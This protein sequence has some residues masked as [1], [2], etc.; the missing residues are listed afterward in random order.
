MNSTTKN[1][2]FQG[3]N[4]YIGLDVHSKNWSVTIRSQNVNVKRF[5]MN[6]SP[7]ELYQHMQKNYPGGNYHSVYEAGTCGTGIF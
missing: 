6:P 7:A 3:Q 2:D 1:I 4:F 5:S